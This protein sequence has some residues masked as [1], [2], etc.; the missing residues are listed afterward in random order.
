MSKVVAF[1]ECIPPGE[2]NPDLV[3]DLERLLEDAKAGQ[4]RGIAYA[5]TLTTGAA[6][7]GWCGSDGARH[8]LAGAIMMLHHRYGAALLEDEW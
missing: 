8:P 2:V 5:T 3:A 6:A 1:R 7:T 4:L